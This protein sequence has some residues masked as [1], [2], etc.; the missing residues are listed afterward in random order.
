[1]KTKKPIS[2][3]PRAMVLIIIL[4]VLSALALLACSPPPGKAKMSL[5]EFITLCGNG[6][7]ANIQ[8]AID[9]GADVNIKDESGK[10]AIDYASGT[11]QF[12]GTSVLQALEQASKKDSGKDD[13][14]LSH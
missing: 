3:L 14:K 5:Q 4:P 7:P 10:R 13:E 12:Q 6:A 2:K 8:S 1:M 11:E 9:A